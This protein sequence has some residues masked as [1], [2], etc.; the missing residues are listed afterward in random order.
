[1]HGRGY[2]IGHVGG[3]VVPRSGVVSLLHVTADGI[4]ALLPD[5]L[6]LFRLLV[7]LE[8]GGVHALLLDK[9]VGGAGG[10]VVGVRAKEVELQRGVG[11]AGRGR[12]SP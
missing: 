1:M 12:R 6:G 8:G 2:D 11:R 3:P 7:G 5:E 4:E 10:V 9:D